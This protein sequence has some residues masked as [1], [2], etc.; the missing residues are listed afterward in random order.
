MA[1]ISITK[2]LC[3]IDVTDKNDNF[4]NEHGHK[5]S[6]GITCLRERRIQNARHSPFILILIKTTG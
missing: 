6:I 4:E 3:A 2:E 5:E 1:F